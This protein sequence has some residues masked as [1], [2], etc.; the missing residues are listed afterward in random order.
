MLN[1]IDK[2]IINSPY[3]EPKEY[4]SYECTAR[5]FSKVE[6]RR[7][8]GYVMA[9]LGSR[10]SDDP[11]IFVEISLVNDIRKCV[12]KWRE[13]DYQRITGITKGKDDDR[14]KVKHD[15]LDEWVQAVNTHGGFGKWAWAVSYYPS[16][17]EG[18][19]EQLR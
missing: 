17:L 15:F 1:K 19:L 8:A 16:D 9:T 5:I 4:W 18:I 12:K 3:E 2:L 10:S 13:N 11:G 14:N 6:G 7:S